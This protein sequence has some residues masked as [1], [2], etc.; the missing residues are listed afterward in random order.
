MVAERVRGW[1]YPKPSTLDERSLEAERKR[2]DREREILKE[3][4]RIKGGRKSP[5]HLKRR[6]SCSKT[7]DQYKYLTGFV[8]FCSNSWEKCWPGGTDCVGIKGSVWQTTAVWFALLSQWLRIDKLL[9]QH[10]LPMK[11]GPLMCPFESMF[12]SVPF[13]DAASY[14][15]GH[16]LNCVSTCFIALVDYIWLQSLTCKTHA[17]EWQ[18]LTE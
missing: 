12:A 16:I 18:D 11:V 6:Q 9:I 15:S 14:I 13:C 5:G 7:T 10:Y 17:V 4:E 3:Q 1:G 8:I 2:S